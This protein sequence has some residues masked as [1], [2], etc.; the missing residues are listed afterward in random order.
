[1]RKI[2]LAL[3]VA[4]VLA[5]SASLSYAS[6]IANWTFETSIPATAGPLAPEVGAGS[7][8]GAHAGA[9]V[10]SSPAGNGSVHS[11]SSN[12]WAVGDYYQFSVAGDGSLSY[13]ILGDANGSGTG[14]ANFK[15]SYSTDG[16]SFTDLVNY[17]IPA[18]ATWSTGTPNA[19]T[20]GLISATVNLGSA[21][22]NLYFRLVDTS[23][24]SISGA[25]VGTGGTSRVDN[26]V[27]ASVPEPATLGLLGLGLLGVGGT[28]LRRR[29]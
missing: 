20:T 12:L 9:S 6:T 2:V 14:P 3:S 29:K 7:A 16:T 24:T 10:Y 28:W 1:M 18:G 21:P 23:T 19:P 11:F 27:I 26:I 25:T 15:I 5:L 13:S 17:S 4:L 22:T 8:T